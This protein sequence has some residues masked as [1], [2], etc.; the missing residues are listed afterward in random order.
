VFDAASERTRPIDLL[1]VG[2]PVALAVALALF[3]ERPLGF[4]A[5]LAMFALMALLPLVW[6][7]LR[8]PRD[9]WWPGLGALGR[10]V[11]IGLIALGAVGFYGMLLSYLGE[12]QRASEASRVLGEATRA[13]G[14][15]W[16][17]IVLILA[18][19]LGP[20]SEELFFR[21]FL[22]HAL[23]RWVPRGIAL[24]VQ[25]TLF[26][27]I[28]GSDWSGSLTIGAMG[29]V[30]GCLVLWRRGLV[31]AIVVHIGFN[32]YAA[33]QAA[34]AYQPRPI[35]G[36]HCAREPGCRV[37]AAPEDGPA[38]A[39]GIRVGDR[40]VRFED[41]EVLSQAQLIELTTA[42]GKPGQLVQLEVERDG[43]TRQVLVRLGTGAN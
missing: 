40:I 39:Q 3:A 34:R 24:V 33:L 31:A 10:E 26:A 12:P 6:V 37:V 30:L 21:C 25:A 18:V 23:S 36:V 8:A 27:L 4:V 9:P 7:R 14:S 17:R 22:M 38:Y 13:D 29:L 43:Q 28:H 32:G 2:G 19:S 1:W 11:A 20:I 42:W 15:S 35:I 16:S 41:R 5:W